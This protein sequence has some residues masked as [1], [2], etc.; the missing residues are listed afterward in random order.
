MLNVSSFINN[1]DINNHINSDLNLDRI[2]SREVQLFYFVR[3]IIFVY[4]V[5]RNFTEARI[6]FRFY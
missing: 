1:R 5:K 2:A 4:I 3:K 6:L